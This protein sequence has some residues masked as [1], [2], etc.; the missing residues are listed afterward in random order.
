[1]ISTPIVLSTSKL[2]PISF[3]SSQS[4]ANILDS[5][6]LSRVDANKPLRSPRPRV[7]PRNHGLAGLFPL[8]YS[9][10]FEC[11]QILDPYI[12]ISIARTFAHGTH[13]C[14]RPLVHACMLRTP[15]STIVHEPGLTGHYIAPTSL[16][17]HPRKL[18]GADC[19]AS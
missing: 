16:P 10:L 6:L 12:F 8:R 15:S 5:W 7:Q 3:E 14:V 18:F 4:S 1:M 2:V 13:Q 17:T 11:C 19:V 9:F